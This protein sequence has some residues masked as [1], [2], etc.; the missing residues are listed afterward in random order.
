LGP[1]E[2]NMEERKDVMPEKSGGQGDLYVAAM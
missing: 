1:R 2:E